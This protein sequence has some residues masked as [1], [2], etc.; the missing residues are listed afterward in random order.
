V[1][2]PTHRRA[3]LLAPPQPVA[4]RPFHPLQGASSGNAFTISN[5]LAAKAVMGM[6]A[7]G[8]AAG[9]GEGGPRRSSHGGSGWRRALGAERAGHPQSSGAPSASLSRR[10]FARAPPP[11]A[12]GCHP[13]ESTL[14]VPLPLSP[15]GAQRPQATPEAV[16]LRRT[17]PVGILACLLAQ[18][19]GLMFTL[20]GLMWDSPNPKL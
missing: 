6:Q 20:G 8:P 13:R 5:I 14:P 19:V 9:R 3:R 18:A 11:S 15:A 2:R 16:F 10:S 1:P 12:G 4:W 17:L 7:R